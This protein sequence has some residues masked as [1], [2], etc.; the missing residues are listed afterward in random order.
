MNRYYFIASLLIIGLAIAHALWG[1]LNLFQEVINYPVPQDIITF[2]QVA[3]HQLTVMLGLMGILLF[4]FTLFHKKTS[5]RLI[6]TLLLLQLASN[7]SLFIFIARTKAQNALLLESIPQFSICL[8]ILFLL[9][10]GLFSNNSTHESKE[11]E[12]IE[13]E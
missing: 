3:W 11:A 4:F 6:A 10:C 12:N 7:L 8:F 9:L 13:D 5:E 1:E 2:F